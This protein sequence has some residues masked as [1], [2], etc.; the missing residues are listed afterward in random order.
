MAQSRTT[1]RASRPTKARTPSTRGAAASKARAPGRGTRNHANA[2]AA[3][4]STVSRG[5]AACHTAMN[6]IISGFPTRD[7]PLIR[8]ALNMGT[9][10]ATSSAAKPAGGTTR[11]ARSAGKATATRGARSAGGKATSSRSRAGGTKQT[12]TRSARSSGGNKATGTRGA[13]NGGAGTTRKTPS[14]SRAK[15]QQPAMPAGGAAA[16]MPMNQAGE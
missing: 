4:S 14:R 5:V 3:V 1:S 13:R 9:R 2:Q 15:A 16:E 10:R 7:R 6:A 8:Q 12:G 11:N